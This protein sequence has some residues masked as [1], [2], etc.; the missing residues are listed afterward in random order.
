[1]A[2]WVNGKGWLNG[3]AKERSTALEKPKH[4]DGEW[5]IT[6]VPIKC[7]KCGSRKSKCYGKDGPVKY[8]KCMEPTCKIKFKAIE[9]E[10]P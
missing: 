9:V 5:A 1:M 2:G 7:P 6:H 3:Y 8:C 10:M 4:S